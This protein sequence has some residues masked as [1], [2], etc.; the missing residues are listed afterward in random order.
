MFCSN[1]EGKF[2]RF[3]EFSVFA[4]S[5]NK[6]PH[7]ECLYGNLFQ[8][9]NIHSTAP[10]KLRCKPFPTSAIS[11]VVVKQGLSF[12]VKQPWAS[13]CLLQ[14][15]GLTA[16]CN[17]KQSLVTADFALFCKAD[18]QTKSQNQFL[19]LCMMSLINPWSGWPRWGLAKWL[20]W[21]F[22]LRKDVSNIL[23]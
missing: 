23:N 22:Q 17:Q 8:I 10:G 13:P 21:N 2:A 1:T 20:L 14:R 6:R 7:F 11:P 3:H 12:L 16:D 15:L 9:L 4:S 5:W 19:D 18:K